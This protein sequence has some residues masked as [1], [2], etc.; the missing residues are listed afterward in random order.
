MFCIRGQNKRIFAIKVAPDFQTSFSTRNAF[1]NT[2]SPRSGRIRQPV[3]APYLENYIDG[4]TL[5]VG[6]GGSSGSPGGNN[7][8]IAHNKNSK[9]DTEV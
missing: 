6:S 9:E 3:T 1:I 4:G 5:R 7:Y 8:F 2:S